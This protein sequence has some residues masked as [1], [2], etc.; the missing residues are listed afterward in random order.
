MHT[1]FAQKEINQRISFIHIL[2]VILFQN[3]KKED[4]S[5]NEDVALYN[6]SI[7][8]VSKY[9]FNQDNACNLTFIINIILMN[10]MF[11]GYINCKTVMNAYIPFVQ[12]QCLG[13]FLAD[14]PDLGR[15]CNIFFFPRKKSQQKSF[16]Y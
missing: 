16:I 1:S 7:K 12:N 14:S 2:G 13:P 6:L 15:Q 11:S 3:S 5:C 8:C 4:C 10:T 9:V